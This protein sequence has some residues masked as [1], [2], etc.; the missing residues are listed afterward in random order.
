MR[1]LKTV[2]RPPIYPKS[3]GH[4]PCSSLTRPLPLP[5]RRPS[6]SFGGFG[7]KVNRLLGEGATK[8]VY[9]VHDTVLDRDV[10]FALIKAVG[11]GEDERERILNE[12]RTMARLGEHPNIMEIYEFGEEDGLPFMVLP[13]MTGGTAEELVAKTQAGSA[14]LNMVMQVAIDVAKGLSFAHSNGVIHRDLK[15]GNVW[16]TADGVAKIG[17]FG[18]AIPSAHNIAVAGAVL[19]TVSYMVYVVKTSGTKGEPLK[20]ATWT[21]TGSGSSQI[22]QPPFG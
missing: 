19:G 1:R 15:P 12:A 2:R 10:A 20:R 18:I 16:M 21:L 9:L 17:D 13:L 11:I 3:P 7:L 14:D 5:S 22:C 8:A 6:V 4:L